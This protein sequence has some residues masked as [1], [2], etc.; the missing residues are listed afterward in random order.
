M[1][2]SNSSVDKFGHIV[3]LQSLRGIA[4][5]I[6]CIGHCISVFLLPNEYKKYL[7]LANTQFAVTL[8]FV[9]SGFVLSKSLLIGSSWRDFYIKRIF[10][11]YPALLV[12]CV[13]SLII[14]I[15]IDNSRLIGGS[16]WIL[17]RFR[18]DRFNYLHVVSSFAGFSA[19]LLPQSWSVTLEIYAS[20]LMPILVFMPLRWLFFVLALLFLY[21]CSGM[22]VF[23]H[24]FPFWTFDFGVGVVI[25][26]CKDNILNFSWLYDRL[27]VVLAASAWVFLGRVFLDSDSL[28]HI[29]E[30]FLSCIFLFCAIGSF[31]KVLSS[32][33]LLKLGD[34]SYALYLLHFPVMY[35]FAHVISKYITDGWVLKT[36]VLLVLTIFVSLF[37]SKYMYNNVEIVFIGQGKRF[38]KRRGFN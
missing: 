16:D 11:I 27:F 25:W 28:N 38:L 31:R 24:N 22:V 18:E 33:A 20:L 3:S 17:A 15:G 29:V 4:A 2:E 6:V 1:N 8:F 12:A 26:R 21:S 30:V 32:D 13:L 19:F 37:F 23:P 7:W 5:M 14:L 35:F 10:R 9:L 34:W 36:S